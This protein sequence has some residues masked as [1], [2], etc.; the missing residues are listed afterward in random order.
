VPRSGAEPDKIDD[1]EDTERVDDEEREEP[2]LL[3]GARGVPECEAFEN[4][5]PDKCDRYEREKGN[6]EAMREGGVDRRVVVPIHHYG[7]CSIIGPM[8]YLGIDY[9]TERVGLAL[10]DE[11][12]SMGFPYRIIPNTPILA[13]TIALLIEEKGV[14]AV[15][16]GESKDFGGAD[17]AVASEARSLGEAIAE[18]AG[19]PLYYESE[20]LTSAQAHR[21]HHP[22]GKTRKP[23]SHA[24]VDAS[25]AALILTSF[26]SRANHG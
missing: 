6:K 14:G 20:T 4:Y 24:R 19:V 8:R 2:P 25:A 1:L 13:E 22:E 17:N 11:S 12:G 9:G 10:S 7:K 16:V 5:S 3:A 23:P 26:L 18:R 21:Q 15:V